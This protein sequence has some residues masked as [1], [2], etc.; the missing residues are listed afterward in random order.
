MVRTEFIVEL[1]TGV[2][3]ILLPFKRIRAFFVMSAI[4]AFEWK[5]AQTTERVFP[6]GF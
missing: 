4:V 3:G 2:A 6:Q 1:V 5:T